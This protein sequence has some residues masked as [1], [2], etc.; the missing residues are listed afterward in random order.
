MEAPMHGS[1]DKPGE[2]TTRIHRS[3][4]VEFFAISAAVVVVLFAVAMTYPAASNWISDAAQAEFAG[5]DQ[6]PEMAPIQLAR[7]A[8]EIR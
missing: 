3:W 6:A 1:I 4:S 2:A 7:P 8:G 5:V